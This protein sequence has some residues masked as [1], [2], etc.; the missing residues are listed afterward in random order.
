M[1]AKGG[2][3][4]YELVWRIDNV[5]VIREKKEKL[6]LL[7]TK[8]SVQAASPSRQACTSAVRSYC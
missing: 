6:L 7:G 8:C 3:V 5:F 1:L 4:N 2:Q